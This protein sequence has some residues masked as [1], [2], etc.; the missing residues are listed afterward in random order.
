[1]LT[2]LVSKDNCKR[3]CFSLVFYANTGFLLFLMLFYTKKVKMQIL[4]IKN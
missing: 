2:F 4:I 3:V 1:M